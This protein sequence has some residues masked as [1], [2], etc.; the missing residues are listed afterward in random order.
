[1]LANHPSFSHYLNILRH[2]PLFSNLAGTTLAEMLASFQRQT[3]PKN[4]SMETGN[5]SGQ[6][7]YVIINGRVKMSRINPDSGRELTI[8]LMSTGD[9]FDVICL[10]DEY[11]HDVSLTAI[12]EVETL[13]APMPEVRNWI[14]KH[15]EFNRAFLPYLGQQIR[16]L[17]EL[18]ADLSLHDTITRLSRLILRHTAYNNNH[19][20]LT[21]AK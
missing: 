7:L 19:T 1:M 21:A 8:F 2:T 9:V 14:E 10:L 18:A 11:E 6:F 15:P 12:D 3:W 16:S 5:S 20:P 13:Y 17:E 4:S